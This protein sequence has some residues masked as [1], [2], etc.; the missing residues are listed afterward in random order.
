MASFS[1]VMR[2]KKKCTLRRPERNSC[3]WAAVARGWLSN[4]CWM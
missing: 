3:R 1:S 2:L 4:H